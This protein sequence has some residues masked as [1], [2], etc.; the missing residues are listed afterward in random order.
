MPPLTRWHIKSAFLYLA[1]AMT[2]GVAL[3][4]GAVVQLPNWLAYLSP[5]F[6]HLIMVGWVTQLIFGV[7]F[8]MFPIVSKA[9]PRG[10]EKVGWATYVLLNGGLLLRVLSEPLNATNPRG[11]WGWGLV[12]SAVMQW[13]AA[14]LFVFNSWPRVRERYRGE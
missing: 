10:N 9:R 8:W 5:A 11:I 6:F 2:L 12:V 7:I 14:M 13:L 4:L 1:A 3:A